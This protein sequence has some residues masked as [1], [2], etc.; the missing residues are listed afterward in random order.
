MKV[1]LTPTEAEEI[2][3]TALCN[4]VGTG[5]MDG[6]GIRMSC[7]RGQYKSSR[8]HLENLGKDTCYEDV[9]MQILRDGGSLT[10]VDLEGEGEMTRSIYMT[11]VHAR[12]QE[13]DAQCIINFHNEVDD[14]ADADVVLQ[15]VFFGEL[16]FG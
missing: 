3:Y 8:E 16:I 15:T 7:D 6:Y 5:Y 4:A 12:V 2:F 14:A 10:F 11:D 1:I 13:V 9:L